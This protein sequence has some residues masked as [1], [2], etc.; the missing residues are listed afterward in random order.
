M[1]RTIVDGRWTSRRVDHS[2]STRH[3]PS[4]PE[5]AINPTSKD[6]LQAFGYESPK[7]PY[8]SNS[9]RPS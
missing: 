1:R 3:A 8:T 2:H 9:G 7:N 6:Y 5:F 4:K